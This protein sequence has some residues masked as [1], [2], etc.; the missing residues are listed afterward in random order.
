MPGPEPHPALVRQAFADQGGQPWARVVYGTSVDPNRRGNQFF[1]ISKVSEMD[2]SG[3]RYATRF[4]LDRTMELPWAAE[5]FRALPN[6]PT[7]IIGCLTPY[8]RHILQIQMSYWQQ[9]QQ[10]RSEDELPL[11]D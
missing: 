1:T 4:C 8:S 5:Y 7:P 2:A 6:M 3:L 9:E 10:N 11:N